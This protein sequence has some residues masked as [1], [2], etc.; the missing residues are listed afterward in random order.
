MASAFSLQAAGRRYGWITIAY[1]FEGFTLYYGS[2]FP[3]NDMKAK[4]HNNL[5]SATW[6]FTYYLTNPETRSETPETHDDTMLNNPS[7]FRE[8]LRFDY[9]YLGLV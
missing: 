2:S 5:M 8:D 1:S 7:Y 6:P 4:K 3:N 9:F